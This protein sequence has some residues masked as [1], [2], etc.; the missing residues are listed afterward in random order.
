MVVTRAYLWM[1]RR[2]RVELALFVAGLVAMGAALALAPNSLR[3]AGGYNDYLSFYKPP[4]VNLLAGKGFVG[5]NGRPALH[6]PPGYPLILAAVYAFA[7]LLHVGREGMVNVVTVATLAVACV[8]MFRVGQAMFGRTVGIVAALLWVTYPVELLM[9]PY[10]FSEVPFT[11]VLYLTALV[12]IDGATKGVP[13]W[14]RMVVVGALIGVDAL[15]RPQAIL[16]V[17]PYGI[18][19]WVLVRRHARPKKEPR[20]EDGPQVA[21]RGRRRAVLGLCAVMVVAYG[22]TIAPWEIWVQAS[23]GHT[24]ALSDGGPSAILNGL[25][26]DFHPIDERGHASLPSGVLTV[27]RQVHAHE[28]TLTSTGKIARFMLSQL[29]AHPGD[30]LEL[31]AIKAAMAFYGTNSL[32]HETLIALVQLPYLVLMMAGLVLAWRSGGTRRWMA[33]FVTMTVAYMWVMTISVLSI[34]RYMGPVLGLLTPFAALALVRAWE[35]VQKKRGRLPGALE[36]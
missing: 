16:L 10:R 33:V 8:L 7:D 22:A 9:A 12:F 1:T 28:S 32:T 15:I 35:Q 17:V 13:S 4:A 19:L 26:V 11:P 6:D 24:I 23:T 20:Q 34:V 30:V 31:V 21:T 3:P 5:L 29:K 14:R 2:R 18:A 25:T 27:E 36:A